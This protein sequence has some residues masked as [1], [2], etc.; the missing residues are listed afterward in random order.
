VRPGG[1]DQLLPH[2]QCA[3]Q[4]DRRYR[5]HRGAERDQAWL[6]GR[7]GQPP[8]IAEPVA[9]PREPGGPVAGG[10]GHAQ[11]VP[12]GSSDEVGVTDAFRGTEFV[13]AFEPVF[14]PGFL[15]GDHVADSDFNRLITNGPEGQTIT[16]IQQGGLAQCET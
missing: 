15:D 5:R 14:A 3:R 9:E 7:G 10:I 12:V 6:A 16:A 1:R 8:G 2:R 4:D 13:A 11:E